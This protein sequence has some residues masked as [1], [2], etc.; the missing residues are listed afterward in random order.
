MEILTLAL[1]AIAAIAAMIAVIVGVRA[2]SGKREAEKTQAIFSGQLTTI[3]T[4]IAESLRTNNE[5]QMNSLNAF[6]AQVTAMSNSLD[7]RMTDLRAAMEVKITNM[8]KENYKQLDEIRHTVDEKLQKTLDERVSESFKIVSQRLEQ[9]YKGLGEMQT[10]AAG[11]G[12][13]KK[14]LSNVKTRGIFGEIQLSRILEQMLTPAQY[15]TNVCTKQGSADPVEF[16]IKIPSK[17]SDSEFVLLPIDAKFPMERYTALQDAYDTGDSTRIAQTMADLKS[18]IR[19]N[20]KKIHSKYIDP[21]YTTDFAIMF[22]PTEGLYAEVIRQT[23]LIE[24]LSRKYLVTISGPSTI[25]AILNSLQMGFRTLAIEKR[26]HEVWTL[27][28][29]VKTEFSRFDEVLKSIQ[30]QMKLANDNLDKLV[31]TRTRMMMSKLR[32]VDAL[33]QTQTDTVF[34]TIQEKEDNADDLS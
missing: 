17:T 28:G 33:P 15:M 11:V 34:E 16:A 9:V 10:L 22:L 30:K 24:E 20:A 13:L 6:A 5:A 4:A 19:E 12:D 18:Y 7:A 32:T 14:V 25:S 21:P 8:Q 29:A 3:Q 31:T 23:E 27:L 1:S 26:S 2:S